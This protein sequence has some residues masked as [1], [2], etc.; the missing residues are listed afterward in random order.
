M[1]NIELLETALNK[2]ANQTAYTFEAEDFDL[3]KDRTITFAEFAKVDDTVAMLKDGVFESNAED[4][5]EAIEWWQDHAKAQCAKSSEDPDGYQ[6]NLF[7]PT[8]NV[9]VQD[10]E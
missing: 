8:M 3:E 2:I 1:N 10:V 4:E 5:D 7:A 6:P 9:F